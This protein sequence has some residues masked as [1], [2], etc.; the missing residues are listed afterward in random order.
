METLSYDRLSGSFVLDTEEGPEFLGPMNFALK[1]L[2]HLD[3]SEVQA[4]EA[5][6]SAF[7][8]GGREI[9]VDIFRKIADKDCLIRE[10]KSGVRKRSI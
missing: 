8:A 10:R 7:F 1:Y 4:R 6:L 2:T 3:F 5:V 9:D